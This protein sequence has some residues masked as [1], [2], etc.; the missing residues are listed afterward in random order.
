MKE[1][2]G[3]QGGGGARVATGA[4]KGFEFRRSRSGE[5]CP[6]LDEGEGTTDGGWGDLEAG[7]EVE[8]ACFAS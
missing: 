4:D 5:V 3:I 8:M 2:A 6:V 1:C 7:E